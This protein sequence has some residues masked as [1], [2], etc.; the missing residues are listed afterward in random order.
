MMKK[1]IL[2]LIVVLGITCMDSIAQKGSERQMLYTLTADTMEISDSDRIVVVSIGVPA[3]ATD[4]CVVQGV[5]S[6]ITG[7]TTNGWI[8]A[9]GEAVNIGLGYIPIKFLRIIARDKARIMLVPQI[10]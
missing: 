1:L 5:S 2:L 9:P 3:W 7:H 10:K 6:T 8:L 4:S